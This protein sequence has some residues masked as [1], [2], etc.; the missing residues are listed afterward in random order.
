MAGKVL[1]WPHLS[2]TAHPVPP[3][4][5][6]APVSYGPALFKPHPLTTAP[7]SIGPAHTLQPC[8]LR[9]TLFSLHAPPCLLQATPCPL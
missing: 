9:A 1:L 6:H 3:L 8:P 4:P 5:G 2:P 7:R